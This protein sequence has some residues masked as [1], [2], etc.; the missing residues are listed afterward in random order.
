M[1]LCHKCGTEAFL[2]RGLCRDCGP[3]YHEEHDVWT[4]FVSTASK[5]FEAQTGKTALSA[6]REFEEFMNRYLDTHG[7]VAEHLTRVSRSTGRLEESE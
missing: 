1:L 2:I 3:V 4:E 5:A 7:D 6:W